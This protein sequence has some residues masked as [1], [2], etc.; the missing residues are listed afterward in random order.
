MRILITCL[1]LHRKYHFPQTVWPHLGFLRWGLRLGVHSR[2][3]H[4]CPANLVILTAQKLLPLPFLAEVSHETVARRLLAQPFRHFGPVR[5]LS[6]WRG[7]HFE[8]ARVTLS[9]LW[10]CQVVLVVARCSRY[11]LG[12]LG[13]SA[14]SRC[15]A[16]LIPSKMSVQALNK[17]AWARSLFSSPGLRTTSVK[18]VFLQD[19]C[20]SYL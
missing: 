12:T 13:A 11:P 7:A 16:V 15:D 5:S 4:P 20:T 6:L 1:V 2:W 18:G 19:L 10:A 8:I 9:A 17:R 14:R 3:S